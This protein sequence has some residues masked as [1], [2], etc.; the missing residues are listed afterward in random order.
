[1]ARGSAIDGG[2]TSAAGVLRH[3]RRHPDPPE[4]ADHFLCVVVLVGLKG[5]VGTG[6][7]SRHRLGSIPL[8]GAHR[9]GDAA[10]HDQGMAVVHQHV[11]PVAGHCRVGIRFPG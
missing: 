8:A 3:M 7:V 4:V 11:P 6:D 1:M 5:F 10:V 2:A 9:L